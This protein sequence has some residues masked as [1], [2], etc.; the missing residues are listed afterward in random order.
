[1]IQD[2]F[3]KGIFV[4][5]AL[6]GYERHE[7]RIIELFGKNEMAFEFVTDGDPSHFSDEIL[8]KYFIPEIKT[9]M[10]DGVLSCTLNHIYA[11]EKM[12][13]KNLDYALIFE[14]DPCFLGNFTEKLKKLENE[15]DKLNEGFIVSLENTS[16]RLPSIW[17][18]KKGKHLYEATT[19]RQC[20]AY[21]I[22]KK[23]AI[24]IL[25]D[26]KVNKCPIVV[27]WWHD[28][29]IEKSIIKMY[30]A[31]P[32]LVEEGSHNGAMSSTIS[33]KASGNYR[34]LAWNLQKAYKLSLA[35]L[36]PNKFLKQPY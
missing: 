6:K 20:G 5:H 1:M 3:K 4:I 36:F 24:N 7:K 13:E 23:G 28:S 21:I 30:W 15:I 26:L 22:D 10:S 19:C 25:N 29:L 11:L 31:H 27:D 14:N 18:T 34:K 9:K 35:R 17:S 12:V 16:L 32:P 33:T 2:L 8:N